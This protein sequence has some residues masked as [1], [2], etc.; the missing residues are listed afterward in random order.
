MVLMHGKPVA[1]NNNVLVFICID[2][3]KKR[4]QV[5]VLR[6]VMRRL[7]IL[8]FGGKNKLGCFFCKM[9][10]IAR[11]YSYVELPSFILKCSSLFVFGKN[12]QIIKQP[13]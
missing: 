13:E 6:K 12:R 3:Y 9:T 2:Y 5:K 8:L 10:K 7:G 1:F 4:L 11:Y